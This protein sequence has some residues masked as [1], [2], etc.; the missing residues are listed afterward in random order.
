MT[1]NEELNGYEWLVEH[2]RLALAWLAGGAGFVSLVLA[3]V[4]ANG[5]LVVVDQ[6]SYIAT[7]GL[8]GLFLLGVAAIAYWAE[9]RDQEL[10]RLTGIEDYL[11][12]MAVAL[13]LVETAADEH[14]GA[15]EPAELVD[16]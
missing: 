6:L 13:G 15:P 9:Q 16:A 4:G 12:T 7:G 10:A 14:A 11:A 5:S 3:M 1:G 2:R 8:L